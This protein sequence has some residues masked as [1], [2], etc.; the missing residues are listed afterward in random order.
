[1]VNKRVLLICPG[2]FYDYLEW[3]GVPVQAL[4]D[5]AGMGEYAR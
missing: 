3:E 2:F 4:L 1:M 5:K